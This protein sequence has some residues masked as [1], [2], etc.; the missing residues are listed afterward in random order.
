MVAETDRAFTV[1]IAEARKQSEII[2]GEGEGER[3]KVFAQAFQLD[4]EFFGFYRS[5]QAYAKSLSTQGTTLVLRPDSEFFSYFG[6][7]R[8]ETAAPN[9]PAQ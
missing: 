9:A 3:N 4:P 7:R 1:R 2:R 8:P 6:T 5:M